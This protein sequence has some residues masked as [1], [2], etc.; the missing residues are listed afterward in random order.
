MAEIVNLR[1]ARKAKVRTEREK[2]AEQNRVIHGRSKAD[3]ERD[4]K[5]AGRSVAFLDGHRLDPDGK[6]R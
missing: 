2:R 3:R 5:I 4:A 1:Q 6:D